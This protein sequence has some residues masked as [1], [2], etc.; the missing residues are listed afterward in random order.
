MF[1]PAPE[2]LAYLSATKS[3]YLLTGRGERGWQCEIRDT[4]T[5]IVYAEGFS[6]TEPAALS[7]AIADARTKQRPTTA[8]SGSDA[9]LAALRKK[10]EEAQ[11]ENIRLK[12]EKSKARKAKVSDEIVEEPLS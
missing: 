4:A 12:S 3:E 9:E 11:Q 1:T 2:E 7:A 10:L 5:G 6:S 8:S